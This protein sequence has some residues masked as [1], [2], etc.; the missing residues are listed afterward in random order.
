MSLLILSVDELSY[1]EM[2]PE[3]VW[4]HV[5]QESI[6]L[7]NEDT[8]LLMDTNISTLPGLCFYYEPRNI[9]KIRVIWYD[10]P[11]TTDIRRFIMWMYVN[12]IYFQANYARLQKITFNDWMHMNT[13]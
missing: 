13:D 11:T 1:H 7:D 2:I 10:W 3:D 6:R 5:T 12:Q 4:H 9:N 8:Y